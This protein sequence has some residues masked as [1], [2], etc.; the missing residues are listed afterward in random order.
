VKSTI[1]PVIA[2]ALLLAFATLVHR[3][4]AQQT[5]ETAEPYEPSIA[6]IMTHQQMR[7]IKLWF[8]GR[9]GNWPL[10]DYEVEQLKDG[11]DDL[12]Q[13]LGGDTVEKTVGAPLSAL[14]KAI[15]AKNSAAFAA[16]FDRLTEGCNACHRALDHAFI[17][18]RRPALLP[19]SDQLF[20]TQKR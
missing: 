11:F 9:S 12:G 18:M 17:V 7:H 8:A 19:Y 20:I 16:A 2:G 10:A 1:V 4:A 3:A 5:G 13:R 6:E 14:E 15:D